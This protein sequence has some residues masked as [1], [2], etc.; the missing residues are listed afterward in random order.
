MNLPSW[1]FVGNEVICILDLTKAKYKTYPVNIQVYPWE[2]P[3]FKAHYIITE[4]TISLYTGSVMLEVQGLPYGYEIIT[5]GPLIK[6][7]QENDVEIF[8][9]L[10]DDIKAHEIA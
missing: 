1:A 5:F 2:L 9:R 7:S 6:K 10:T 4:V 8:T 3:V